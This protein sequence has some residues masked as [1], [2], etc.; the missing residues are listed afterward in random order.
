MKLFGD[1]KMLGGSAAWTHPFKLRP[2]VFEKTPELVAPN[3]TA[4]A[5]LPEPLEYDE[6]GRRYV[7]RYRTAVPQAYTIERDRIFSYMKRRRLPSEADR[8]Y[9]RDVKNGANF[10]EDVRD[11][12][13][14]GDVDTLPDRLRVKQAS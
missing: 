5:A 14:H 1:V 6:D 10:F 2:K 11:L 9:R 8:S 7:F 4:L 12:Q 13:T 3:G